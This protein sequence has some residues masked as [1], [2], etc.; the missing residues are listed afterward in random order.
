MDK[1]VWYGVGVAG[2]AL[3]LYAVTR[4]KADELPDGFKRAPENVYV[5]WEWDEQAGRPVRVDGTPIDP[6]DP[7]YKDEPGAIYDP[8][9][10]KVPLEV[11]PDGKGVTNWVPSSATP[12]S[13][14]KEG[15]G[16]GG[17][18]SDAILAF[19][20]MPLNTV[21][22]EGL[23]GSFVE[24][25]S[26][27]VRAEQADDPYRAVMNIS[28]AGVNQWATDLARE[29][30]LI[31]R[32]S[33]PGIGVG[34]DGIPRAQD[35]RRQ[36]YAD[37]G[38]FDPCGAVNEM[39]IAGLDWSPEE[40]LRVMAA[41]A[42]IEKTMGRPT[43]QI[44]AD[45]YLMSEREKFSLAWNRSAMA[46]VQ[47]EAPLPAGKTHRSTVQ[48]FETQDWRFVRGAM[49]A[50]TATGDKSAAIELREWWGDVFWPAAYGHGDTPPGPD[51]CKAVPCDEVAEW[52]MDPRNRPYDPDMQPGVMLHETRPDLYQKLVDLGALPPN[53]E[54][55]LRKHWVVV[56]DT[57]ELDPLE[58][59]VDSLINVAPTASR[60]SFESYIERHAESGAVDVV[61]VSDAQDY[62]SYVADQIKLTPEG[63]ALAEAYKDFY[64]SGPATP[65]PPPDASYVIQGPGIGIGA[66]SV[67][68]VGLLDKIH[69]TLFVAAAEKRAGVWG[70]LAS[71]WN[72][73]VESNLE[74]F[75]GMGN[76]L[77]GIVT[78]PGVSAD[79]QVIGP[80]LDAVSSRG[81][82]MDDFADKYREQNPLPPTPSQTGGLP[83]QEYV[84]YWNSVHIDPIQP[85]DSPTK[86]YDSGSSSS[87]PKTQTVRTYDS[88]TGT[89]STPV[90][91]KQ[92]DEILSDPAWDN[93]YGMI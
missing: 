14:W 30:L 16:E 91:P 81:T 49:S 53:P 18:L 38:V 79:S 31:A 28:P 85:P 35:L 87:K 74:T 45:V 57:P 71:H 4:R 84:E 29:I 69:D 73:V 58:H 23:Y 52:A 40:K 25:P 50:F 26:W 37:F 59:E 61:L 76:F 70:A 47:G 36:V 60:E 8:Y 43:S 65:Y 56:V 44:N 22:Y 51:G 9:G 83:S 66:V 54:D 42:E 48:H 3:G 33:H 62:R 5:G 2:I 78:P 90:S 10:N 17:S 6:G 7:N 88:N 82:P 68:N 63:A 15:Q 19:R 11:G 67:H 41:M 20:N 12:F 27:V 46:Y 86:E 55:T 39:R 24:V 80:T 32:E 93:P 92:A 72:H 21:Q 75:E 1:K 77:K 64:V 89:S 13:P 34:K